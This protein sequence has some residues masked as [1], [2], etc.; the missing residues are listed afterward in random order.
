MNQW[1]SG[2]LAIFSEKGHRVNWVHSP[3]EVPEGGL[4][5]ML[6]CGQIVKKE[7][8]QRNRKN[9]VVHASALPKGKGWPPLT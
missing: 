8:L 7:V 9:L 4:C 6:S 5:F 2:L 1:I 3:D